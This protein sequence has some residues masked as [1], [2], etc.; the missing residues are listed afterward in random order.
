MEVIK[1]KL[2]NIKIFILLMPL[3]LIEANA[4][5]S[6]V[7]D[8]AE[9]GDTALIK[10]LLKEGVEVNE[11]QGDGMTALHWAAER[12]NSELAEVLIYA[13]ANPMA[14]TR[15]GQYKPL[16]LAAKKGNADIINILLDIGIDPNTKTANS[17]ST[18]LHLAAAS[19]NIESVNSLLLAGAHT[20][21]RES[22]WGQ[23]PL[24]FA[25]AA[26]HVGVMQALLDAGADP[27]L[28]SNIVDVIQMEKADQSAEKRINEIIAQ[29]K[30]KEGGGTDWLPT[31]SQV[32]AAI[33]SGREIQRNWSAIQKAKEDKENAAL[34]TDAELQQL[35][36]IR[37]PGLP[38]VLTYN[39]DGEPVY[40]LNSETEEGREPSRQSYGQMVGKWGGL[41]PLL[42]AIRQGHEEAVDML[43]DIGVGINQPSGDGTTPLL[44]TAIN[45]QFDLTLKL[46][47]KG[48]NPN[49][50]SDAGTSPL[51]AVL[52]RTWAPKASYAHPIEHQQQ[53]ATH[54]DVIR[55]LL[56]SGADPNIRMNQ[57]LWYT[58]YTF[59]IMSSG[60]IH[61]AGA[62]PF[63]RA[64]QALDL[65]SMRLLKQYGANPDIA[66]IKRP[67]RRRPMDQAADP[68]EP[69]KEEIDHSGL[70]PIP[71]GG[72]S[73]YPIH[74]AAGAGY[75][76]YFVG[77][78]HQHAPGNWLPVIK[79][80]VEKCGADV[81]LRDAN[82][83]TSLHHAA[84]R[85]DNKVI[86]YLLENGADVTVVS[87]KGQTTVDMANGPIER[88]I[89]YRN[90]I[91]LLEQLG[92]K[93]NNNCMSC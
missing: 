74:L 45:G 21:V 9:N 47:E 28:S 35:T 8:A 73:I 4:L 10:Q 89:P 41:T 66:N 91:D 77:T 72:P 53:Q 3:L 54:L 29:F 40:E 87:R 84:S 56:K 59:F 31:A 11:P 17:G 38:T 6:P 13:G 81:N 20:N 50:V 14:G 7:A 44:M 37:Q 5:E 43:L 93:N 55:A 33:E 68:E 88:V 22:A 71:D 19:G 67:K 75:G 69:V 27:A 23:T 49:I 60:G 63:W 83:Y 79:F 64:T 92:A 51:F 2:P 62:T 36:A 16:H 39:A 25:A 78:A 46:I 24:I 57:H 52:E 70:P 85:G 48:A 80:L 61:F 26:N 76:Q 12:G 82:G 58:E 42:H 15:I 32:Q 65:D 86:R 18:A 90:T 30:E 34:N 1:I